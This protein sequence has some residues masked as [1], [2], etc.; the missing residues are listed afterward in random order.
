[1]TQKSYHHLFKAIRIL[2]KLDEDT[3]IDFYNQVG[4]ILERECPD[5]T[6]KDWLKK[7]LLFK[8]KK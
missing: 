8:K 2:K 1:M 5:F 3:S 7:T 6:W 4:K